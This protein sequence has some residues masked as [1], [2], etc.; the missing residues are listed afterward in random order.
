MDAAQ[1]TKSTWNK[2]AQLYEQKF[3]HTHW[4]NESYDVLCTLVTEPM[5][6]ILDVGCGPGNIS[7]YIIDRLPNAIIEGIDYAEEMIKLAANNIPSGK[8][9]VLDIHHLDKL[10]DQYHAIIAGFCIPYL[11][12]NACEQFI[13]TAYNLLHNNGLLYLSFVEGEPHQSGFITGST[14]DSTYFY[15]HQ[16]TSLLPILSAHHFQL[17][18]QFNIPYTKN[19]GSTDNH[20]VIIC[21]K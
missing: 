21:R 13:S 18:H 9:R 10:Q 12:F 16:T 17:L 7:T 4:Y 2:V 6:K 14:G 19:D 5:P 8:F 15:Y 11:S 3:M 20:I 1:I